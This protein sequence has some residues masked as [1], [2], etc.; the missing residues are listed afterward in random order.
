MDLLTLWTMAMNASQSVGNNDAFTSEH[1]EIS[2]GVI[3]ACKAKGI[4]RNLVVASTKGRRKKGFLEKGKKPR[5]NQKSISKS[6][7]S[8]ILLYRDDTPTIAPMATLQVIIILE[9][10][11]Y[12]L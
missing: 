12:F 3:N 6:A 5:K 11:V 2:K 7:S 1:I 4:K 8:A 10:L 9:H